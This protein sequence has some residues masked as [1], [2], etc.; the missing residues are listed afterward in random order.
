[1]L[2]S[3]NQPERRRLSPSRRAFGWGFCLAV[4]LAGGCSGTPPESF[5]E[6]EGKVT[7]DGAKLA[8]VVV[9]FYPVSESDVARPI[10]NGTSDDAGAYRLN[11]PDGKAG[12]AVGKCRVV[13]S[14][15]MRGRSEETEE[16]LPVRYTVAS[17]TPLVV[18]VKS[19]KNVINL[20]LSR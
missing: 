6:V 19:G 18:D 7:L 11:A 1:M 15:P 14:R 8:G 5:A 4:A 12:A 9:T 10:S 3:T 17:D 2:P 20:D 16:P 13:V